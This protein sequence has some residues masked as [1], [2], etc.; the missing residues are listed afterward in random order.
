V[1]GSETRRGHSGP[2]E[3]KLRVVRELDIGNDDPEM[4]FAVLVVELVE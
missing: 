2:D 1:P 4:H 3:P